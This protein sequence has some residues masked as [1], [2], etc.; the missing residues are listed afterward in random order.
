MYF[1]KYQIKLSDLKINI[2]LFLLSKIKNFLFIFLLFITLPSFSSEENL[3]VFINPDNENNK[4]NE[5]ERELNTYRLGEGDIIFINVNNIKYLSGPQTIGPDGKLHLP[6]LNAFEVNDYTIEGLTEELELK[7]KPYVKYPD[8][9]INIVSYRPVRIYVKGEVKKPGFYTIQ[10]NNISN[11]SLSITSDRFDQR[12]ISDQLNSLAF[13]QSSNSFNYQIFPSVF[14]AIKASKGIT[15]YSDLSKVY[16]LRKIPDLNG[17]KIK[18]E[19]K[20]DFLKMITEGDQSQNIR[21]F[22]GDT[23]IV[24]KSDMILKNQFLQ[25]RRS[26]LTPDIISVYVSGNVLKQGQINLPKGSGLNQAVSMSGGPKVLSGNVEFLRFNEFG[27]TERRSFR[28]SPQARINTKKNPILMD[29]DIVHV[30]QSLLDKTNKVIG[31]LADPILKSYGLYSI[32]N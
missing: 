16:V 11:N 31:T 12:N 32:F 26:N 23:I 29:G 18:Y 7:Y 10:T 3:K 13:K 8:I 27:E 6:E 9:Q 19:A 1:S 2:Y 22:D 17:E 21:I 24:A 4:L 15:P 5:F 14:D 20:L 28:F 30:N 25:A